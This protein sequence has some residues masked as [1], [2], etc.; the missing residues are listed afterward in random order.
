[1]IPDAFGHFTPLVWSL[2][3]QPVVLK[4]AK[5][6]TGYLGNTVILALA[7]S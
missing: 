5:Y 1:M 4:S 6:F 7:T 3:K 2:T